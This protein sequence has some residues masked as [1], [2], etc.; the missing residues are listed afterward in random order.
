MATSA[1]RD[2]AA[3]ARDIRLIG[4][5]KLPTR[6]ERA[7]IVIV[8]TKAHLNQQPA[9]TALR[10]GKTGKYADSEVFYL[11]DPTVD[12]FIDTVR[13]FVTE[14]SE[15]LF[16]F[17]C[18]TKISQRL[19]DEKSEIKLKNGSVEPALLFDLL[20]SKQRNS[21][22]CFVSDGVHR[23]E[24]WIPEKY[25][26]DRD[27]I[28]FVAPYPDPAQARLE[29]FDS[30]QEGV[31]AMELD[32]VLKSDP[33][34]NAKKLAEKVTAELKAFGMKMFVASYPEAATTELSFAL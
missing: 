18:A 20:N 4:W 21:R 24:D 14:V 10:M 11:V 17:A 8:N 2:L 22:V 29:Q 30:Q 15:F 9:K 31:F 12:E 1:F 25:G 16:I 26:V 13:H 19:V 23:T 3:I 33:E 32:K 5:K 28:M 7:S 6:L 27:G 34:I